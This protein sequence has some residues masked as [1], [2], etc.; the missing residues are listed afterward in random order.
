MDGNILVVVGTPIV[1]GVAGWAE[2]AFKDGKISSFEWKKLAET[3]LKLG[4]P[5]AAL[6]YGFKLPVEMSVAAPIIVDYLYRWIKK[7]IEKNK[8]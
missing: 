5:A 8:K 4:V 7:L 1:R 2:N 3:I 6:Y